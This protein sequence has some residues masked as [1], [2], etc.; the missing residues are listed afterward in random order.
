MKKL[1][2]LVLI[3]AC[4][5]LNYTN[6]KLSVHQAELTA[7][8]N[9]EEALPEDVYDQVWQEVDFSN[10]LLCS[11]TKTTVGSKLISIGCLGKIKVING[12]WV[13]DTAKKYQRD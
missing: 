12:K 6:P 9:A 8:I 3:A 7:R 13:K 1:T 4:F 10:L 11:V 2:L 5:Y